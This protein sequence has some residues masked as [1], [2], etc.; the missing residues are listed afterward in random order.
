MTSLHPTP[1]EPARHRDRDQTEAPVQPVFQAIP[2]RL[3]SQTIL[4]L[5]GALDMS[6]DQT[7]RETIAQHLENNL[8]VLA[9]DVSDLDFCDVRGLRAMQWALTQA[10]SRHTGLRIVAADEWLCRLFSLAG[11]DDLLAATE[12]RPVSHARGT[13][14]SSPRSPRTA[15]QSDRGLELALAISRSARMLH[16]QSSSRDVLRHAVDLAA[17]HVSGATSAAAALHSPH[18]AVET[19]ATDALALAAEHAQLTHHQG[20]ALDAGT[21]PTPL[22]FSEIA[23]ERRWPGFTSQARRLGIT[24]TLA[25]DLGYHQSQHATLSVYTTTR[26]GFGVSAAEHLELLAAHIA[27]ALD[28]TAS[29]A[30]LRT[31]L[32]S[33]QAI[34]EATGILMGRHHIDSRAAVDKLITASQRT[35]VK[36]RDVAQ[37][38][39]LTGQDPDRI[40]ID[41]LKEAGPHPGDASSP[42]G[43]QPWSE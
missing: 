28:R 31:A 34:G 23:D 21:Q 33:R 26:A 14:T 17:T 20:P 29:V 5:I 6:T 40:T 11:A 15:H 36:L 41:D 32:Y 3:G 16:E 27:V 2:H 25:C 24:A 19:V 43:A 39:L 22:L 9:L 37:Y 12:P 4:R 18:E 7:L 8:D 1:D 10:A 13:G 35:N 42:A 38:V 30:S